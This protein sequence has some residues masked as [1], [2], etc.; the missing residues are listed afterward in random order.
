MNPRRAEH[1]TIDRLGRRGALWLAA[2]GFG[3]VAVPAW[4][5]GSLTL[6]APSVYKR[7]QA[8]TQ[9][10]SFAGTYVVSA[11]GS[12][13]SS[14][15]L[16]YC[17]GRE[18]IDKIESLD[19]RPQRIYRHNELVH[20]FWPQT[21]EMSIE[22]RDL[23]GRWPG[24]TTAP[25]AGGASLAPTPSPVSSLESPSASYEAIVGRDD[26]VA[27][28]EAQVITLK[29]RDSWRYG[30]R[31][32]LERDSGLLLRNDL[33]GPKGE[34]LESAGFS[35]LQLDV[36]L[37]AA[38]LLQE[39]NK[40]QGYKVQQ[41]SISKT[42]LDSEGWQL[43]RPVPGFKPYACVRRATPSPDAGKD[44]RSRDLVASTPNAHDAMLQAIY[45]DGLTHVSLFI[46]P[47][48]ASRHGNA[49][50]PAT[51][52]ATQVVARREGG[53]WITAVGEVPAG[54]LQAFASGLERLRP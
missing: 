44:L 45:T 37:Q 48:D 27:G 5:E 7:V 11:G 43:K 18:Q 52:G 46:E 47:Y 16:H 25:G 10:R 23:I 36:K 6:D 30:Q 54:T 21:H 38:P 28:H 49:A 34:V 4:A 22:T 31:W 19:G 24:P 12:M 40:L 17:N 9:Q 1:V 2:W 29:P 53:W 3:C 13:S 41:A 42:T 51:I 39:M 33:L 14:R 26:R 32:W 15:I 50:A 8:S 35:E 20:V